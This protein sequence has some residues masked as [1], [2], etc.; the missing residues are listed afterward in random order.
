VAK[1]Y[2]MLEDLPAEQEGDMS[3]G[4]AV[5]WDTEDGLQPSGDDEMSE[6]QLALTMVVAALENAVAKAQ[7][8]P[9]LVVVPH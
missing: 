9:K 1:C 6:A 3:L 7:N 5:Q 2:L 4:W 8:G